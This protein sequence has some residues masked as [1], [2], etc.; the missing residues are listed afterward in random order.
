MI[1][2]RTIAVAA[3]ASA[4]KREEEA[5]PF[6]FGL[7]L[8]LLFVSLIGLTTAFYAYVAPR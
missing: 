4:M 1:S 3:A 5:K 8:C 2:L 7:Q 6:R